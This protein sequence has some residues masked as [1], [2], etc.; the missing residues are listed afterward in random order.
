MKKTKEQMKKRLDLIREDAWRIYDFINQNNLQEEFKKPTEYS[1]EA[2]N[3][4]ANI[5][6]AC[7]LDCNE[8]DMWKL[9]RKG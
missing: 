3:L 8:S 5:L 2:W 6:I 9:S 4:L 7:D 1:D